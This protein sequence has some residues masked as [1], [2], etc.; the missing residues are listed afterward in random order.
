MSDLLTWTSLRPVLRQAFG[1]CPS[2]GRFL[3]LIEK[4]KVPSEANHLMCRG[5]APNRRYDPEVVIA[6]FYAGGLI[7]MHNGPVKKNAK[8]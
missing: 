4:L 7:T 2:Y 8:K 5:G 6:A 3:G 1:H